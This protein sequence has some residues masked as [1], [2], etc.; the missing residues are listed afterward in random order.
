[1]CAVP[2]MPTGLRVMRCTPP[3]HNTERMLATTQTLFAISPNLARNV[4]LGAPAWV[5]NKPNVVTVAVT[6]ASATAQLFN[7]GPCLI[8]GSQSGVNVNP[9]LIQA[10]LLRHHAPHTDPPC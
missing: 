8:G 10:R 9:V 1:M 4:V 6:G 2:A 7:V 5:T 3:T